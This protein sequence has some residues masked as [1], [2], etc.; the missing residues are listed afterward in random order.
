MSCGQLRP[1][2]A[3]TFRTPVPF[4]SQRGI[5]NGE[6]EESRTVYKIVHSTVDEK[7]ETLFMC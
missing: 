2:F 4:G 1:T 6:F 7:P 3:L 5:L